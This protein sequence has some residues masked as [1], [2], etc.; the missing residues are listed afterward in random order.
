MASLD[1][2]WEQLALVEDDGKKKL[3]MIQRKKQLEQ[4]AKTKAKKQRS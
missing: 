2:L 4:M 3:K 1:E